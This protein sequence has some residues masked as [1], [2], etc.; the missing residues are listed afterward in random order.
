[1]LD[2]TGP[3]ERVVGSISGFRAYVEGHEGAVYLHRGQSYLVETLDLERRDI[4]ARP[5]ELP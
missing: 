5:A 2:T 3:E 1:M 4:F